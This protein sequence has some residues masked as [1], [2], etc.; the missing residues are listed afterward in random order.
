MAAAAAHVACKK[1][2]CQ[3]LCALQKV[4]GKSRCGSETS[5]RSLDKEDGRSQ[6][7][8]VCPS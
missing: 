4:C 6:M 1:V 3:Q 5:M 8:E 2:V 7:H